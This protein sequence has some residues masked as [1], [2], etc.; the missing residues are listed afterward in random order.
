[1]HTKFNEDSLLHSICILFQSIVSKVLFALCEIWVSLKTTFSNR[2]HTH[3]R[4]MT[5]SRFQTS[6]TSSKAKS[7]SNFKILGSSLVES[8]FLATLGELA[9]EEEEG[10]CTPRGSEPPFLRNPV[11]EVVVAAVVTTGPGGSLPPMF[12]LLIISLT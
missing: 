12:M 1:M 4:M 8:F 2:F 11:S 10:G 6:M 5:S 3:T 7:S 9:A